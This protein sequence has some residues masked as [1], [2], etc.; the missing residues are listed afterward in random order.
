[1]LAFGC[2]ATSIPFFISLEVGA[3]DA[4]R[5]LGLL[6]TI[7][8]CALVTMLWMVTIVD[9]APEFAGAMKPRARANEDFA[10]KPFRAVI[11]RGSAVIRSGVVVTIGTFRGDTDID[12]D[13]RLGFRGAGRDTHSGNCGQH[14]KFQFTHKCSPA[15]CQL[16]S[17]PA[18]S[19]RSEDC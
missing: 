17:Q 9:V 19:T 5:R 16:I 12:A 3:V 11:A 2:V 13:L 14:E 10:I 4:L 18:I 8:Q 1:M 6:A 7:W 15:I